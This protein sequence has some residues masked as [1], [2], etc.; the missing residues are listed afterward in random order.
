MSVTTTTLPGPVQDRQPA[1]TKREPPHTNW[2]KPRGQDI[3][4]IID[5]PQAHIPLA[6]WLNWGEWNAP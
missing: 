3:G 6:D 4:K 2:T 5:N 1:V